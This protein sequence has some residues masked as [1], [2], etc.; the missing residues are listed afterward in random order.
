MIQPLPCFP[1]LYAP[2]SW[3]AIYMKGLLAGKEENEAIALANLESDI[4]PRAWM[5]MELAEETV[6][7]IPVAGGASALKN[8][9]PNSWYL[10]PEF[11]RRQRRISATLATIYGRQPFFHLLDHRLAFTTWTPEDD[12]RAEIL[13]QWAFKNTSEIL[14][15]GNPSLL[16]D[17]KEALNRSASRLS[18]IRTD[19]IRSVNLNLSIFDTLMRLGPDAIFPLLPAFMNS[20]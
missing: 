8:H 5:R 9:N 2:G 4:K 10:A 16:K 15:L 19:C 18:E 17:L 3:W 12:D 6:V 11:Y 1:P 13:C 7:S 14:G 20:K